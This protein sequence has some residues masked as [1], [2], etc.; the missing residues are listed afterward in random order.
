MPVPRKGKRGDRPAA[1][2]APEEFDAGALAELIAE[3]DDVP[4][5]EKRVFKIP[6]WTRRATGA[7]M[8]VAESSFGPKSGAD[9]KDWVRRTLR[10]LA[11]RVDIPVIPDAVEDM[12]EGVVIG[13]LVDLLWN[14]KAHKI[15]LSE[16]NSVTVD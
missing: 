4:M 12:I 8:A 7:L 6:P 3:S 13:L 10:D 14:P 2:A 11:R 1:P 16:V 9:K 5:R 15:G